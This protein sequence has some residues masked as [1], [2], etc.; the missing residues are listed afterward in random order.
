MSVSRVHFGKRTVVIAAAAV[1]FF[2]ALLWHLEAG[3]GIPPDLS[4]QVGLNEGAWLTDLVTRPIV[5][6]PWPWP[7]QTVL[8][9]VAAC[10]LGLSL[11]W[12][13]ERLIYNDWTRFEALLF[14]VFLAASSAIIGSVAGDHRPIA[15]MVACIAVVPGIR[16]IESVGDVQANMSFGLVLPLLF[17]A[18]PPLAPLILP[19][20]LF[21]ALADPVA[22]HDWRAFV[23]MFLV[24]IMPTLLV[25]TGMIGLFGIGEVAH[26][27]RDIYVPAFSLARLDH[28]ATAGAGDPFR[29]H[30]TSL[31]HRHHRL[32]VHGR[33][34]MA[35]GQRRFRHH[36]AALSG[37]RRD[38]LFLADTAI[39][40]DGGLSRR[41]CL[42][43]FRRAAAAG[44]QVGIDHAHAAD[45]RIELERAGIGCRALTGAPGN[46]ARS[47]AAAES[48]PSA[49]R[50]RR[51]RQW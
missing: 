41:L 39:L 16:R 30:R 17:L 8:A 23:A 6:V 38:R 29:L 3:V 10:V 2:I 21:G 9:V 37:G 4:A 50:R 47:C 36:P 42:L 27:V 44:A 35:A 32:P 18:G 43:A 28:A 48:T 51:S 25:F 49:W 45:R 11:A 26:L 12:L 33:Q 22:R 24:A 40:A 31:R 20:A 7:P 34:A 5:A 1:G 46:P 14:V 13:Y 19:L 15:T